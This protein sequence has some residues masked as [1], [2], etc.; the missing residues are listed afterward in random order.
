M[1]T[2]RGVAEALV[3][4][5]HGHLDCDAIALAKAKINEVRKGGRGKRES[6]GGFWCANGRYIMV[7]IIF[8][9]LSFYLFILFFF[10]LILSRIERKKKMNDGTN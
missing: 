6:K 4:Y 1:E 8:F 9:C 7:H 3:H 10:F 5:S 2:D